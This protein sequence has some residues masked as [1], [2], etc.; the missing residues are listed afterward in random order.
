[1][2]PTPS[3]TVIVPAFNAADVLAEALRSIGEQ[4]CAVEV[5]VVDDGSTDA[6]AAVAR[7][8]GARLLRQDNRGPSATRNAGL[9]VAATPLVAFLDADDLWPAGSLAARIAYLEAH[10][11]AHY[12]QGRIRDLWPGLAP[13]G[14]DQLDAPRSGFNV[15]C[16]LFQRALFDTIGFF[17]ESRRHGEDVDLLVRAAAHGQR[18]GRIADVT[19]IYR[20]RLYDEVGAYRRHIANLT[21]AVKRTLDARRRRDG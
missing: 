4:R 17:D 21:G 15:G 18:R 20:R 11:D 10:P 3:V 9:A 7:A 19:L 8:C 13:T 5:V 12:V 2:T 6:T 1:V 16:A 14:G